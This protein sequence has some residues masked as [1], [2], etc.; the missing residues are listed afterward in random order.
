MTTVPNRLRELR[1]AAGLSRAELAYRLGLS[2]STIARWEWQRT[3]IPDSRKS[4]IARLLG[5]TVDEL[6]AGWPE[7][8]DG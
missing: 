3:G 2:E 4:T 6:M 7:S 8:D 1:E 5:T